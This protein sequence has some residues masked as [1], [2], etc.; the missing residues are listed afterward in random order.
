ML[1]VHSVTELENPLSL[2]HFLRVGW[3][4]DGQLAPGERSGGRRW[5][6]DI[7]GVPLRAPVSLGGRPGQRDSF[8]PLKCYRRDE[9]H[10]WDEAVEAC[11]RLAVFSALVA[12]KVT[13]P[14]WCCHMIVK[15]QPVG[16][17]LHSCV[18][19]RFLRQSLAHADRYRYQRIATQNTGGFSARNLPGPAHKPYEDAWSSHSQDVPQQRAVSRKGGPS[20][21]SDFKCKGRLS[22]DTRPQHV[23]HCP[24]FIH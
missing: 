20:Q 8:L 5:P 23:T 18:A 2:I 16:T 21:K 19:S 4:V 13:C 9:C 3:G 7:P 22:R 1:P 15:G 17:R 24:E 10:F 11:G 12:L 6:P 14:R